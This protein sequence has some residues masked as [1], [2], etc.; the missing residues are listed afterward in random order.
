MASRNT[1]KQPPYEWLHEEAPDGPIFKNVKH[2]LKDRYDQE[3]EDAWGKLELPGFLDYAKRVARCICDDYRDGHRPRDSQVLDAIGVLHRS[4]TV[5]LLI[6][7]ESPIECSSDSLH[8]VRMLASAA[9]KLGRYYERMMARVAEPHAR[10]GQQTVRAASKGHVK[11]H[12][13]AE[14]KKARW[15]RHQEVVDELR[16][17]NPELSRCGIRRLAAQR[18]CVSEST[19]KRH[20]KILP[21]QKHK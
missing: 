21:P 3:V 17:D 6:G 2:T 10:R 20:T 19:I 7:P 16:R 1:H 12:G 8:Y 18:C 11:V 14:A 9:I 4:T 15:Q 5:N 13:T